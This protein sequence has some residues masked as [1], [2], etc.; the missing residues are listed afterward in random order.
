MVSITL[1][2]NMFY[3]VSTFSTCVQHYSTFST[4]D[5]VRHFWDFSGSFWDLSGTSPSPPIVTPLLNRGVEFSHLEILQPRISPT[6]SFSNHFSGKV[7]NFSGSQEFP[8]KFP[9]KMLLLEKFQGNP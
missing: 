7:T 9:K 2:N 3:L 4:C 5:L 8:R 6:L 1:M